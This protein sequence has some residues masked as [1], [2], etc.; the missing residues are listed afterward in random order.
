M[1]SI[2]EDRYDLNK[3]NELQ[4]SSLPDS[5]P[6]QDLL[7][8]SMAVIAQILPLYADRKKKKNANANVIKV[9][10]TQGDSN[11][12][13]KPSLYDVVSE[14]FVGSHESSH[15]T[16]K[17]RVDKQILIAKSKVYSANKFLN[18][19]NCMK[20][21]FILVI[22]ICFIPLFLLMLGRHYSIIK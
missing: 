18:T 20:I 7:S 9:T 4:P 6:S 1:E 8:A 12:A 3:T 10:K 22:F 17:K 19:N 21:L 14:H 13:I 16:T 5:P 15:N 2:L 11:G